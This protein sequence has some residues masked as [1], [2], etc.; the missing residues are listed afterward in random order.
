[1]NR[2][3]R[4]S[5]YFLRT[6]THTFTSG[7]FGCVSKQ[8]ESRSAIN[9]ETS[10]DSQTRD[11]SLDPRIRE[12]DK[13]VVPR[14]LGMT[15]NRTKR[16]CMAVVLFAVYFATY[17]K[18]LINNFLGLR[19]IL[20][21]PD[22]VASPITHLSAGDV[23]TATPLPEKMAS[24]SLLQVSGRREVSLKPSLFYIRAAWAL[25]VFSVSKLV[26]IGLAF[27]VLALVSV[28]VLPYTRTQHAK[29]AT[30]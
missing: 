19:K 27:A 1:M 26:K 13:H 29:A 17:L 15:A 23:A 20:A 28:S 12:D 2:L 3:I 16:R 21:P 4:T 8:D 10:N 30:N 14:Y 7:V 11:I 5:Q 9:A 6:L 24:E 22:T 25:R 18:S